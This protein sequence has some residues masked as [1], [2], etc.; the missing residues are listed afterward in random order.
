MPLPADDKDWQRGSQGTLG[1]CVNDKRSRKDGVLSENSNK[2]RKHKLQARARGS[3]PGWG[4]L[5][6]ARCGWHAQQ[7]EREAVEYVM[8]WSETL[9]FCAALQCS[10]HPSM[11]VGCSGRVFRQRR[12]YSASGRLVAAG[13]AAFEALAAAGKVVGVAILAVPVALAERGGRP[14]QHGGGREG[15]RA[16]KGMGVTRSSKC[17]S[18]GWRC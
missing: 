17:A 15:G 7:G 3:A 8:R 9:A 2:R 5:L 16:R 13:G 6:A 14:A 1:T 12:G 10:G 11:P 18:V 4:V